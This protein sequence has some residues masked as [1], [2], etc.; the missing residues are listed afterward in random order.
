MHW[1]RNSSGLKDCY[2][3]SINSYKHGMYCAIVT[4]I[5]KYKLGKDKNQVNGNSIF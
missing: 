1:I 5:F 2:M 4:I 3:E